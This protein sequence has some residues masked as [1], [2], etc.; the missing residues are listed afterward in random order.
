MWMRLDVEGRQDTERT[1]AQT[2]LCF[3]CKQQQT[4]EKVAV[5]DNQLCPQRARSR[6]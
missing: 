4:A 2:F 6:K 5:L 3:C 1:K